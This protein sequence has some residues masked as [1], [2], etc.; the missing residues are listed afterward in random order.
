MIAFLDGIL[1]EKQPARV[2]VNVNGVGYEVFIPLSSYERLPGEGQRVR[3]LTH[4][5]MRE[6]AHHL[7]GFATIEEKSLFELLM[8]TTGI[9]PKIALSILGGMSARE[10]RAAI[11]S[12]D[13]KRLTSISGVGKKLAERMIVEL[14]DKIGTADAMQAEFGAEEPTPENMKARDAVLALIALGFTQEN[15]RRM[16]AQA[17]KGCDMAKATVEDILKQALRS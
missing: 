5:Y 1:E 14:K 12:G 11:A 10:I 6:D 3:I 17:A 7:Y 15:A 2:V 9:G 8:Q 4:D 13:V 16:V